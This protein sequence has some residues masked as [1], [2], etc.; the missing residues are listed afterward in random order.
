MKQADNEQVA[1]YVG[2]WIETQRAINQF[3]QLEVAPYVGAW[4][5][6]QNH[7]KTT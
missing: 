2:A 7:A 4:I 1:P 3:Q 5:E 6:T